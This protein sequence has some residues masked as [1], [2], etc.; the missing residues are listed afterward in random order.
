MVLSFYRQLLTFVLHGQIRVLLSLSFTILVK[1]YPLG[2]VTH[3]ILLLCHS[4]PFHDFPQTLHFLNL[5]PDYL[6]LEAETDDPALLNR[7]E[8][9]KQ[10]PVY[11]SGELVLLGKFALF[12]PSGT[13]STL[14]DGFS[15]P[16][17][18]L[19]VLLGFL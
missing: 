1:I 9:T 4:Y 5:L 12:L 18:F 17:E 15:L 14:V 11:F 2:V 3:D 19:L 10:V 13:L 6:V 7:V 16:V 8:L